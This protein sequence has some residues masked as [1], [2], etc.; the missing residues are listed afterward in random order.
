MNIKSTLQI[1]NE[2]AVIS[3]KNMAILLGRSHLSVL[4]AIDAIPEQYLRKDM[5]LIIDDEVFISADGVLML[6]MSKR[7]LL[8]RQKIMM[9]LFRYGDEYQEKSWQEFYAAMPPKIIIKLCVLLGDIGAHGIALMVF[10][11]NCWFSGY[12]PARTQMK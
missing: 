6:N 12:S 8:M 3:S 7:H 5:F 2:K 10:R 9:A 11:A 1:R 4:R